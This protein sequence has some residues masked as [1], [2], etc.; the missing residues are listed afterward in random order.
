MKKYIIISFAVATT[1]TGYG[2]TKTTNEQL[3]SLCREMT[4]K[5]RANILKQVA[6]NDRNTDRTMRH[7]FPVYLNKVYDTAQT[8]EIY[9][10]E[11]RLKNSKLLRI[12][13]GSF[14]IETREGY[15][16]EEYLIPAEMSET[17]YF[18]LNGYLVKISIT[19]GITDYN[20]L[21]KNY[22][23]RMEQLD[24][25]YEKNKLVKKTA[26]SHFGQWDISTKVSDEW[27]E[28]FTKHHDIDEEALIERAYIVY[29]KF[30]KK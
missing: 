15:M 11:K 14:S 13:E 17:E 16:K 23:I 28:L 30:S 29:H 18:F 20:A 10:S 25:M 2:Q 4:D 8:P 9:I 24:L 12:A 5:Y 3:D 7:W 22:W 6:N 27:T 19:K 26:Y 1:F 21:P